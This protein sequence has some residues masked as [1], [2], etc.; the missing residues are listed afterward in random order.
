V[1]AL[2]FGDQFGIVLQIQSKAA[3]SHYDCTT[4]SRG[5]NQGNFMR[6]SSLTF[7]D[8]GRRLAEG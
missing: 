4:L 6:R 2:I 1:H 7:A 3:A 8:A 5:W